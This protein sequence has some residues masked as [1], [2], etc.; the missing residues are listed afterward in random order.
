MVHISYSTTYSKLAYSRVLNCHSDS[1]S[2]PFDFKTCVHFQLPTMVPSAPMIH[3]RTCTSGAQPLVGSAHVPACPQLGYDT[4]S[5][6]E[7]VY[8]YL[9]FSHYFSWETKNS[10]KSGF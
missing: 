4:D 5:F 6:T 1:Y 10:S 8:N 9:S 2:A 3:T 7:Y